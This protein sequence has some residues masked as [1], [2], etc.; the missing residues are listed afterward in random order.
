M[1]KIFVLRINS[2]VSSVDST[3][4]F[5]AD[6]EVIIPLAVID[7]LQNYNGRPEKKKVANSI[8]TYLETFN[9]NKLIT[10]GVVQ[11]NGSKLKIE[12]NH[13]DIPIEM[14]GIT[15][16]DRRIFQVCIGLKKERSSKEVIL[17]SKNKAI[18]YT[19][20]H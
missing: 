4:R 13:H 6:N 20:R 10:E 2:L 17:V 15:E 8:L 7:E 18:R 16:I 1:S 5:G 14:D 9:I 11:E 3:L 19:Y 12:R